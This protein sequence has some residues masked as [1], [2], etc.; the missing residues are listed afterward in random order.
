MGELPN[1]RVPMP[2]LPPKGEFK[3]VPPMGEFKAILP[4]GEGSI[5]TFSF[6]AATADISAP[7]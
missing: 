1:V 5:K 2:K 7:G 6:F 3:T 4:K